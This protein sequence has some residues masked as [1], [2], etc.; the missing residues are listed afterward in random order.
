MTIRSPHVSSPGIRPIAGRIAVLQDVRYRMLAGTGLGRH[1][2]LQRGISRRRDSGY[3]RIHE[4]AF[5]SGLLMSYQPA[6]RTTPLDR[7]TS[8]PHSTLPAPKT[9]SSLPTSLVKCSQCRLCWR[10]SCVFAHRRVCCTHCLADFELTSSLSYRPAHVFLP[11]QLLR[12]FDRSACDA[13]R[14]PGPLVCHRDPDR[15]QHHG[16]LCRPP[17]GCPPYDLLR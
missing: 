17:D 16:A 13:L 3:V 14:A 4:V 15:G 12:A 8:I 2:P 5:L 6:C 9:L 11:R 7:R 10:L 1:V